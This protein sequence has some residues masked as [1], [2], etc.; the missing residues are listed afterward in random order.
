M[1]APRPSRGATWRRRWR[2]ASAASPSATFRVS[3]AAARGSCACPTSLRSAPRRGASPSNDAGGCSS[4]RWPLPTRRRRS[5]SWVWSSSTGCSSTWR[6]PSFPS[7]PS[8]ASAV[9]PRRSLTTASATAAARCQM[10]R[11]GCDG[12]LPLSAP[13]G[14]RRSPGGPRRAHRPRASQGTPPPSRRRCRTCSFSLP[15]SPALYARAPSCRRASPRCRATLTRSGRRP[16]ARARSTSTPIPMLTPW[17]GMMTAR[18]ASRPPPSS[19]RPR[20]GSRCPPPPGRPPSTRRR[21]GC[22]TRSPPATPSTRAGLHPTRGRPC[23]RLFSAPTRGRPPR[24]SASR[25]S[26]GLWKTIAAAKPSGCASATRRCGRPP[27]PPAAPRPR[28]RVRG[29]GCPATAAV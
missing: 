9:R 15:A 6:A 2:R 14:G 28:R 10:R 11:T 21:G 13:S 19:C 1:A 26:A 22:A 3:V 25:R 7:R 20:G 24:R 29:Y 5:A 12:R 23:G 16:R 4:Q 8:A 18:A 17:T 27:P